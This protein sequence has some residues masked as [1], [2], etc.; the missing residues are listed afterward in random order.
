M[1]DYFAFGV[2][3]FCNL[4]AIFSAW[5]FSPLFI[6]V[7]IKK[8]FIT[9]KSMASGTVN[10]T[11]R[12]SYPSSLPPLQID[13]CSTQPP[14]ATTTE[15]K[16]NCC[17][18]R[19]SKRSS[20]IYCVQTSIIAIMLLATY[21]TY[22]LTYGWKI[23]VLPFIILVLAINLTMF[24]LF[25][26]LIWCFTYL[27][28]TACFTK[29]NLDPLP[30]ICD[31]AFTW[32]FCTYFVQLSTWWFMITVV[33]VLFHPFLS[34]PYD[35]QFPSSSDYRSKDVTVRPW[36]QTN[37]YFGEI[38]RPTD[39]QEII[40]IIDKNLDLLNST[41]QLKTIRAVGS[42]HSRARLLTNDI[43]ISLDNFNDIEINETEMTVTVGAGVVV[44]EV[45]DMLFDLGYVILGFGN[46]QFQRFGGMI[47]TGVYNTY[48]SMS[49]FATDIW[50]IDGY[51]N[52]VHISEEDDD[53]L[54]YAA[55]VNIGLLGMFIK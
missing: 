20:T 45:N 4:K 19:C 41:G 12:P 34:G 47:G 53:D 23:W 3:L 26:I 28:R 33:F 6:I 15:H 32:G 44:S 39:T 38:Y 36:P 31:F 11:S 17:Q 30:N 46:A 29:P 21:I 40:D 22:E 13:D 51:G 43:M 54:I 27:F 25:L 49:K 8:L 37:E 5:R 10:W 2:N 42:A 16:R 24:Y 7:L 14:E 9:I 52:D 50:L 1:I 48:G 55:R 35:V 18:K